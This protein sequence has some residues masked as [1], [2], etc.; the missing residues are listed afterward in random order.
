LSLSKH[1]PQTRLHVEQVLFAYTIGYL[2]YTLSLSIVPII[3]AAEAQ[4]AV[5]AVPGMG[6]LSIGLPKIAQ[7]IILV[8]IDPGSFN[9]SI[10][11]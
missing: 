11:K 6:D 3:D 1:L 5:G 2:G 9:A 10:L 7:V 4:Q 8:D